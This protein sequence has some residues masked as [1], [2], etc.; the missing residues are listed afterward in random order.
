MQP[1]NMSKSQLHTVLNVLSEATVNGG[2]FY[3]IIDFFNKLYRANRAREM[4]AT[5]KMK[6]EH[7][8]KINKRPDL[9]VYKTSGGKN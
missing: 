1:I 8:K 4:K 9:T 3:N 2:D 6:S 7:F 5:I